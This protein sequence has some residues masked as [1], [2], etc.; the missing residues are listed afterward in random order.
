MI[1]SW[2]SGQVELLVGDGK[3][4]LSNGPM[5]AAGPGSDMPL[6][7]ADFNHDGYADIVMPDTAIGRWNSNEISVLLGTE[8]VDSTLRPVHPF[9]AAPCLGVSP[10]A[11]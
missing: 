1:D 10:L 6:R 5:F 3:G 8:N 4:N 7:S 11:T 2:G 9:P